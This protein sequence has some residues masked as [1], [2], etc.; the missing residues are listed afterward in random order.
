MFTI[1]EMTTAD[2]EA[3]YR[4]WEH[5]PGMGL[6]SADSYGGIAAFLK[7]NEG[8]SHVCKYG[9]EIVGTALCGHDGRRGFLYHV[10]VNQG[11]RGKGLAGQLVSSCLIK[12]REQGIEK[13]HLMVIHDNEIG[14]Q[15][16]SN[17]G[18]QLRDQILLYSHDT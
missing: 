12:L 6:S 5:T 10:T 9:D 4:L 3:A 7:R 2:Y 11:H 18:W 1:M 13:C 16:W 17:S 14:K 8:L 15:F